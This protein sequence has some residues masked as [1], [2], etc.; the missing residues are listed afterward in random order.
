VLAL[1]RGLGRDRR[2]RVWLRDYSPG[3]AGVFCTGRRPRT[4]EL[5]RISDLR[6]GRVIW[7]R[8]RLGLFWHVGIEEI[9]E[10]THPV[11]PAWENAA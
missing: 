1:P 4:G 3:G 2:R 11:M 9:E 5:W 7:S 10:P 8:R 6:W